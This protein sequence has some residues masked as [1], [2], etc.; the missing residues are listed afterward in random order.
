VIDDDDDKLHLCLFSLFVQGK[1]KKKK[2]R[3]RDFQMSSF[4]QHIS[5]RRDKQDE[6]GVNRS[7]R[8][9]EDSINPC[10]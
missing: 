6:S 9:L 7:Q 2:K 10:R 4:I 1:K 8:V 5:F 3:E